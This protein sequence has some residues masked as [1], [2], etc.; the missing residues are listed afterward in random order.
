MRDANKTIDPLPDSFES[1]EEAG[2]F[3]DD[4]STM[5]YQGH[6]EATDDTID[7]SERAFE[8]QVEVEM[9]MDTRTKPPATNP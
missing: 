7:V 2:A 1:E 9:M 8:V 6:L 3:C 5:D 4:H